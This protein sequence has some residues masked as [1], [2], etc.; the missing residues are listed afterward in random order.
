MDISHGKGLPCR[1]KCPGV[2]SHSGPYPRD[3]PGFATMAEY[4]SR[5]KKELQTERKKMLARKRY[6]NKKNDAALQQ[7]VA[8]VD[9]VLAATCTNM[10]QLV[11]EKVNHCLWCLQWVALML[12]EAVDKVCQEKQAEDNGIIISYSWIVGNNGW[13]LSL[14]NISGNVSSQHDAACSI[15]GPNSVVESDVLKVKR[16]KASKIPETTLEKQNQIKSSL[17]IVEAPNWRQQLQV[18]L[19]TIIRTKMLRLLTSKYNRSIVIIS[20]TLV[21]CLGNGKNRKEDKINHL[22]VY[23]DWFW[24][25]KM[26][27]FWLQRY[28]DQ[29]LL[30]NLH[31]KNVVNVAQLFEKKKEWKVE[32]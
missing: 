14:Q 25:K 10:K 13:R 11:L 20:K 4:K 5:I 15:I 31:W 29:P 6:Q 28:Q 27:Y 12:L 30:W 17:M 24:L 3:P 7:Q 22:A 9:Y 32:K 8:S 1:K 19:L 16:I 2:N 21:T 26:D 18:M 23:E